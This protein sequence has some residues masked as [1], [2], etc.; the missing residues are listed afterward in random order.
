[1]IWDELRATKNDPPYIGPY[2]VAIQNENGSYQVKDMVGAPYHRNVTLD[3]LKVLSHVIPVP[4]VDLGV[5]VSGQWY[6]DHI[7]RRRFIKQTQMHQYLIRWVGFGPENDEW[8]NARDIPDT[9]LIRE[10][11]KSCN[12]LP[13]ANKR[14]ATSKKNPKK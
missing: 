6:V 8:V 14:P 11:V 1:M 2:T 10:Y 3:Q 12:R 9:S 7:V 13:R 5:S 4:V